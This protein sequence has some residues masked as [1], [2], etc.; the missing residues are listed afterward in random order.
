MRRIAW[1]ALVGA[2]VLLMA[3]IDSLL[4]SL[5][6]A[7]EN[8]YGFGALSGLRGDDK[9]TVAALDHWARAAGDVN[10]FFWIVVHTVADSVFALGYAWVMVEVLKSLGFVWRW[11]RPR[12][13]RWWWS[14]LLIAAPDLIE[15]ALTAAVALPQ[16]ITPHTSFEPRF[17]ASTFR[18]TMW[19]HVVG[20]VKYA[21]IAV[22][23]GMIAWLWLQRTL[24]VVAQATATAATAIAPAGTTTQAQQSDAEEPPRIRFLWTFRVQVGVLALLTFVIAVPNKDR[25]GALQQIP[26]VL[27]SYADRLDWW[28]FAWSS[29]ALLALCVAVF[30]TAH[31]LR[32][33]PPTSEAGSERLYRVLLVLGVAWFVLGVA[34]YFL[35][36]ALRGVGLMGRGTWVGGVD[37]ALPPVVAG[38]ILIVVWFIHK[39]FSGSPPAPSR[40]WTAT[41]GR[42]VHVLTVAPLL[43]GGLGIVRAFAGPILVAP[44]ES[45]FW[46]WFG[47]GLGAAVLGAPIAFC[48]LAKVFRREVDAVVPRPIAMPRW[49]TWG[50]VLVAAVVVVALG[51][52]P[53]R[54]APALGANGVLAAA[55]CVACVSAGGLVGICQRSAS[56]VAP[57]GAGRSLPVLLLVAAI[58]VGVGRADPVG[59]YHNARLTDVASPAADSTEPMSAAFNRW[60]DAAKVCAERAAPTETNQPA[61]PAN[62][63]RVLPLVIVAAAG[64]G[65]RAAYWTEAALSS[66]TDEKQTPARS[67]CRRQS[68]FAVST[69]SGA[70]L[71]AA[72]WSLGPTPT[73]V[74]RSAELGDQDA[75]AV[76]GATWLLRDLPRAVT[77]FNP[78]IPDRAAEMEK[79]WEHTLPALKEH[80]PAKADTWQPAL[81]FNGTDMQTGCRVAISRLR[82]ERPPA[83]HPTPCDDPG[84]GG[85]DMAGTY[86][87]SDFL[88]PDTCNR[89]N[90]ERKPSEDSRPLRTSTAALLSARFPFVT[91][92]GMLY[93][94]APGTPRRI[95]IGDGGYVD[96]SAILTALDIWRVL[97][98]LVEKRNIDSTEYLIAPVF[99]VLGNGYRTKATANVPGRQREL[100]APLAGLLIPRA[101]LSGAR[102]EAE[103][104]VAFSGT[105]PG[106]SVTDPGIPSTR[107]FVLAPGSKPEVSAP[108]GWALSAASRSSLNYQL[109]QADMELGPFTELLNGTVT[110][111]TSAR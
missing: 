78:R 37:V 95:Q 43:I 104:R 98:P 66:I 88:R 68:I 36:G 39:R 76:V 109:T 41:H 106:A 27:R 107:L 96:N 9:P 74:R 8:S 91:P 56:F 7:N 42:V 12:T 3:E 51:A 93:D 19:L 105:V 45:L 22:V 17:L 16:A 70:S 15:N 55:L 57:N 60:L 103:A 1:M 54:F 50:T 2:A 79:S 40:P 49:A 35:R 73:N 83:D 82:A 23:L 38:T 64:G 85:A 48:V 20:L 97:E 31:W 5:E 32:F 67:A 80:F 87:V 89:D 94:C 92:T 75:L 58:L 108:L 102:L 25:I 53:L 90:P 18:V 13:W 29:L 63:R 30:V 110:V 86:H 26:D 52:F 69:V 44:R 59:T 61:T 24:P 100:V 46:A 4:R 62:G 101:A 99:A 65:I 77:G 81:V 14:V 33:A 28:W 21:M 72:A 84:V 10:P 111:P 47:I 34:S 71:G 6:A 11:R